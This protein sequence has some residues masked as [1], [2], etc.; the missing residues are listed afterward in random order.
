MRAWSGILGSGPFDQ[1]RTVG[2]SEGVRGGPRGSEPFDQD[3]TEENKTGET[4]VHEAA[5]LLSTVVRSPKLRQA[6]AR[7]ALESPELGRGEEGATA[8]LMAGKR[9]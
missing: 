4:D 5:L 3:R 7:V 9:P 8:N 1:D 2:G 6:R